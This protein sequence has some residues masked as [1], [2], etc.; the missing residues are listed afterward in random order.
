MNCGDIATILL[1]ILIWITAERS[2]S[3][4]NFKEIGLITSTIK[5]A[6]EQGRKKQKVIKRSP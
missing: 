2:L 5:V 1:I 4:S 6:Q 3:N